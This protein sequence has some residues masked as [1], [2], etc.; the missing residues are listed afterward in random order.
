MPPS[1]GWRVASFL[2]L[3]AFNFI[4]ENVNALSKRDACWLIDSPSAGVDLGR[5]CGCPGASRKLLHERRR[6]TLVSARGLERP[7]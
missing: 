2:E 5:V 4:V 1:N 7:R 6:R 3:Q